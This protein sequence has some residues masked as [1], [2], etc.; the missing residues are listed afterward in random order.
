M[1]NETYR[2]L[3]E[4]SELTKQIQSLQEQ[5]QLGQNKSP[6]IAIKDKMFNKFVNT[7]VMPQPNQG[8]MQTPIQKE[9]G[10]VD[11]QQKQLAIP[12]IT[13]LIEP[14]L[15]F[16]EQRNQN[17]TM[18]SLTPHDRDAISFSDRSQHSTK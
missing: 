10:F 16:A 9:H 1:Q 11:L 7:M 18:A 12:G 5:S 3:A 6:A 2:L 14:K 17:V 8:V 13:P 4:A 15:E